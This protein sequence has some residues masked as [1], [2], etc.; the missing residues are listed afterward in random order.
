MGRE[1]GLFLYL[2]WGRV[3]ER[4]GYVFDWAVSLMMEG[5]GVEGV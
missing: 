4:E 1:R 2:F 5:N 3:G